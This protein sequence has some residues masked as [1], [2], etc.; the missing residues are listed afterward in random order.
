MGTLLA[1]LLFVQSTWAATGQ[2]CIGPILKPNDEKRELGNPAGGGRVFNFSVQIGDGEIKS[3][4]HET[5]VLYEGLE[6]GKKHWVRIR[7]QGKQVESFSFTFEHEDSDSLCL[8]FSE[9]YETWSLWPQKRSYHLCD[10][11]N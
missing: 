5:H 3:L 10:C 4:P 8:W 6:L 11:R 9:L 7:N 2:V 1:G